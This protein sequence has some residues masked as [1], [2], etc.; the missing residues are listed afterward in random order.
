M[1]I[2]RVQ[3]VDLK[4]QKTEQ[5]AMGPSGM[6]AEHPLSDTLLRYYSLT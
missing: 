4:I 5:T 1:L 2:S 6:W 3:V